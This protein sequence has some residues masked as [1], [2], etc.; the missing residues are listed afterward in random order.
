MTWPFQT[1]IGTGPVGE[2]RLKFLPD[3]VEWNFGGEHQIQVLGESLVAKVAT[4]G[5][6]RTSHR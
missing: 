3:H 2:H 6:V 1:G 5:R 4:L